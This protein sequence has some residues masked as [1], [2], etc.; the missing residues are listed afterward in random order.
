MWMCTIKHQ[1]P[2]SSRGLCKSKI[3]GADRT[4]NTTYRTQRVAQV[5]QTT[6]LAHMEVTCIAARVIVHQTDLNYVVLYPISLSTP[7][8]EPS[9]AQGLINDGIS[10]ERPYMDPEVW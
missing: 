6:A 4:P 9:N 1:P 5:M 8:S 2:S 7:F 10:T 3:R